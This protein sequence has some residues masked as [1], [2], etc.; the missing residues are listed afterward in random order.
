MSA[1][2]NKMFRRI[3]QTS[4]GTRLVAP[5]NE[6][7]MVGLVGNRMYRLA[8]KLLPAE[9]HMRAG[10]TRL[11]CQRRVEKQTPC[12][13]Q[14][15]RSPRVRTGPPRSLASSLNML[16]SDAGNEPSPT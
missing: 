10:G 6:H 11:H 5:Q 15:E 8:R 16:R 13:A 14:S 12:R 4:I 7:A 1:G 3:D 2:E 9:L